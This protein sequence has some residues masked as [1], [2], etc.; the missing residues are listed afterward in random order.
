MISF[1]EALLDYY[2]QIFYKDNCDLQSKLQSTDKNAAILHN[3]IKELKVNLIELQELY[4]FYHNKYVKKRVY[5]LKK[6][7]GLNAKHIK[8]KQ[9]LKLKYKYFGP[10]WII[11][12]IR[13]QVYRL[14]L[15]AKWCIHSIFH[16][17]LLER[18]VTKKQIVD[19]KI[20]NQLKFEE[21]E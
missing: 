21:G 2:S 18:D 10:F 16:V 12:A 11:E 8:I 15:L 20:A 9:N 6:S 14:K 17:L 7:V 4:T 5:W 3:L 1:L 19:Q 13:N